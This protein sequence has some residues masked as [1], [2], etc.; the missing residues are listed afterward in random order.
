MATTAGIG[1]ATDVDW[2]KVTTN[3]DG[4]IN[5]TL[6]VSNGLNAYFTIYD[7]DGT[8]LLGSAYTAGTTSYSVDGLA[9]GTYYIQI[10]P[11]YAGQMPAYTL[12]NTLTVATP[13]NDAEPDSTR[14]QALV[15]P[16]NGSKTGHIGYYYNHHRD[17][18]DVY[19]VTTTADGRLRLTMASANGQNIYIDL[20]DNNGTTLLGSAYTTGTAVLVNKDGFAAGTYYIRIHTYYTTEFAPYTLSDSLFVPTIANDVEPDST[21]AQALVLPLNGSKTGHIGYYYNN[22]RDSVDWYKVTTNADGRLRL[23]MTSANGQNVYANLYDNN[24]TTL[25]ASNYTVVL[26]F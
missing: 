12:S 8:T 7:N 17:S 20:Y 13:A 23:T 25:L 2:W 11:Y 5:L 3:A 14:A 18:V 4:K 10:Y 19:K 16:L 21:R 15:L 6:D 22:H 26:L 9:V 1:T 24:G